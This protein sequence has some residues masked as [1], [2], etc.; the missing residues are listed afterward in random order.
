M[1]NR[2]ENLYQFCVYHVDQRCQMHNDFATR[3]EDKRG[4][5]MIATQNSPNDTFLWRLCAVISL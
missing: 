1:G 3:V 5:I 2:N 4:D